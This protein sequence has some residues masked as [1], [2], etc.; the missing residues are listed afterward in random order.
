VSGE[1][2][3]IRTYDGLQEGAR[4][5]TA[6]VQNGSLPAYIAVVFVMMVAGLGA[7]AVSGLDVGPAGTIDGGLLQAAV[8]ALA[9]AMAVAIV[10]TR[11]RFVAVLML[12]AVGYSIAVI[13]LL[14]GAPDLALTQV[15]VETVTLVVFLLV[16]RHLPEGYAPPPE[17][18]PRALRVAVALAVGIA[19]AGFAL[20]AGTARADRPVADRMIEESEPVGGGRNVVNV[21]L[22]DIRGIDTMG[23]ITVL[24]IAAAGVANLVRAARRHD[25]DHGD[26]L[27]DPDG[28]GAAPR[29]DDAMSIGPRS[30]VFD[31]VTRAAFPIILLV[32][33]YVALRGHNAPGGGFAGG[34]IAGIAFVM[35]FLAGGSPLLA[36]VRALPTSGLIGLGLLMAVATGLTSAL[37]GE[38]FLESDIAKLHVPLVGDVKLVSTAVFDLGVYLLV[39]G[40]VLSVLTHLGAEATSRPHAATI[41]GEEAS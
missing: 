12:G 37:A 38:E 7:A 14:Y 33:V 9:A 34:L 18:A 15:L 19:V 40:V 2:A 30:V 26:P 39:L 8:A 36:R 6:L 32:S 24:A 29:T 5:V 25:R 22:I 17:W 4:R 21:I 10:A 16:L 1:R 41:P 31:Q 28:G 35:R 13:F 20:A 23:E 11:R 3:F 27:G